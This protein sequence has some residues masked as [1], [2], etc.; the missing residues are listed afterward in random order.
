M[1]NLP[2][3]G[4]PRP[5]DL[6]AHEPRRYVGDMAAWIHQAVASEDELINTL[7]GTQSSL[8]K[9]TST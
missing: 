2:A 5:I 7:L 4:M 1:V 3:I 6:Q 8:C 9:F